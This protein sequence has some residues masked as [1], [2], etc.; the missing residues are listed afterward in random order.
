MRFDTALADVSIPQSPSW[1]YTRDVPFEKIFPISPIEIPSPEKKLEIEDKIPL[2][3]MN[4]ETEYV[5]S[6]PSL[7]YFPPKV[8]R[9]IEIGNK[10]TL[11]EKEFSR[12]IEN[13]ADISIKFYNIR[14]GKYIAVGFNGR[15]ID[16]A[17]SR[18]DLLS[19]LQ[20]KKFQTQVF[21]WK[22]G[23]DVFSG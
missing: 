3:G 13:I 4:L 20:G 17:D 19:K 5:I 11:N 21:V 6:G 7:P 1:G 2:G 8:T 10:R 15:I 14:D 22:A 16:V 9:V 23:S 18:L 12:L